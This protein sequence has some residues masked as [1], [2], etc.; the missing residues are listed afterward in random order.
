[1]LKNGKITMNAESDRKKRRTFK[2]R[3]FVY[4]VV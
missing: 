2:V 3:L 1:M 4:T